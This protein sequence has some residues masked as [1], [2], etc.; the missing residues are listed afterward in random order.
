MTFGQKP[1]GQGASHEGLKREKQKQK[2][3]QSRANTKLPTVK[4]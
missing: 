4:C 2:Q 3:N 1:E